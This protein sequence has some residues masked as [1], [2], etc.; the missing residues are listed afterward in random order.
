MSEAITGLSLLVALSCM[1]FVWCSIALLGAIWRRSLW[2]RTC[3]STPERGQVWNQR[4]ARLYVIHTIKTDE[5]TMIK[6]RSYIGKEKT[7]WEES[8]AAWKMRVDEKHL[9]LMK[10]ETEKFTESLKKES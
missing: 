8:L 1:G 6:I 4:G 2:A 3:G 10:K 7:E 9:Y 5:D